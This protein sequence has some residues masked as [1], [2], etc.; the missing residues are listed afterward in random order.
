MK[1][2]LFI[3]QVVVCIDDFSISI[4]TISESAENVHWFNSRNIHGI[5][6]TN[7]NCYIWRSWTFVSGNI[8]IF[9]YLEKENWKWKTWNDNHA[10]IVTTMIRISYSNNKTHDEKKIIETFAFE[11]MPDKSDSLLSRFST[12]CAFPQITLT[13][14][15]TLTTKSNIPKGWISPQVGKHI[16]SG[17]GMQ[18]MRKSC[19]YQCVMNVV[20]NS[21]SDSYSNWFLYVFFI[22]PHCIGSERRREWCEYAIV[23]VSGVDASENKRTKN[24]I[25]IRCSLLL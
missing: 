7:F 21:D 18:K 4:H 19:V 5:E 3:V 11:T 8:V 22:F 16:E 10:I 9:M 1:N 13:V 20:F 2:I 6:E 24:F 15:Y 17:N 12:L 23:T 14:C 25:L